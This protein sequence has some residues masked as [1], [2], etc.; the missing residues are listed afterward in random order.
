MRKVDF[1]F[2]KIYFWV[3]LATTIIHSFVSPV[4]LTLKNCIDIFLRYFAFI[5]FFGFAYDKMLPKR[6][7][8]KIFSFVFL[9]W[10]LA[11]YFLLYESSLAW[12]MLTLIVL[13]PKY[14]SV[15]VFPIY[16]LEDMSDK[17]RIIK[18]NLEWLKT[19]VL[20]SVE[21]FHGLVTFIISA[22]LVKEALNLFFNG[23]ILFGSMI[24]FVVVV[25]ICVI[26]FYRMLGFG[27]VALVQILTIVIFVISYNTLLDDNS[28]NIYREDIV[29]AEKIMRAIPK[30]RTDR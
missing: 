17:K 30:E 28:R 16:T 23:N 20:F 21:I 3:L 24:L 26:C 12:E 2:Y 27:L 6:L 15:M 4:S 8:W 13:I 11:C 10:E 19:K 25:F 22:F 18:E 9:A 1:T 29:G 5:P 7:F 14:F